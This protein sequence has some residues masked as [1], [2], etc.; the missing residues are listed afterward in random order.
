MRR[1]LLASSRQTPLFRC[2]AL[3]NA[4]S[5]FVAAPHPQKSCDFRGPLLTTGGASQAT[6]SKGDGGVKTP[7]YHKTC[8]LFTSGRILSAPAV[9]GRFSTAGAVQNGVTATPCRIGLKAPESAASRRKIH[10][11]FTEKRKFRKNI[12]TK[13]TLNDTIMLAET[14]RKEAHP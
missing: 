2:F 8:E 6:P 9:S 7:P 1:T 12:I 14:H 4:E 11:L 3:R 13:R 10:V 5:R